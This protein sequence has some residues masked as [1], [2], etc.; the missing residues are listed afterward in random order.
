[1]PDAYLDGLRVED[2]AARYT[3]DR[4]DG[5]RTTVA[6]ADD[7]IVG[8]ATV[9]GSELAAL[10]VDPDHWRQGVGRALVTHALSGIASAGFTA[11]HLWLLAGNT[12]GRQFYEAGG[13]T[14]DGTRRAEIVWGVAVDEVGYRYGF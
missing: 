11:A 9:L 13:W 14:A 8:F 3:F 12:R 10:H 5:P 4:D 6:V 2:R 7:A 1:M